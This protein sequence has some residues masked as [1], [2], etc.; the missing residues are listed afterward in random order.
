[1]VGQIRKLVVFPTDENFVASIKNFSTFFQ[2]FFTN[3][4]RK[5]DFLYSGRRV[6]VQKSRTAGF[7]PRSFF[8]VLRDAQKLFDHL[9]YQN[10]NSTGEKTFRHRRRGKIGQKFTFVRVFADCSNMWPG[11]VENCKTDWYHRKFAEKVVDWL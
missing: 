9:Q 5:F 7:E 4:L 6:W 8:V 2:N 1:M 10:K 3:F 11:S